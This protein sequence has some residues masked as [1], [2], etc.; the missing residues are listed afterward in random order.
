MILLNKFDIQKIQFILHSEY[1][2][3]MKINSYV[4]HTHPVKYV[5]F[6]YITI[7]YSPLSTTLKV[8]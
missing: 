3:E 2:N 6:E 5:L 8:N 7:K 4:K 1:I